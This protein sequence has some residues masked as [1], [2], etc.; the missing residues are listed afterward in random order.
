MAQTIT[1]TAAGR[2]NRRFL[3]LALILAGLSAVLAYAALSRSG[4]ETSS[5]AGEIPVVV[6]RVPIPAG[7]I[8]AL[9]MVEVR[10][11]AQRGVGEGAFIATDDVVGRV[12]RYPI[13]PNEQVLSSKV[14]G[15]SIG[16]SRALSYVLP[17][18]SRGLAISVDQV[19]GAGGLV[20][21]GDHVDVI[22]IP[23]AG[24]PAFTLLS[25]VEVTAVSQTIV[26]V[27][28]VAPGLREEDPAAGGAAAEEQERVRASDSPPLP[29]AVTITMLLS[30]AQAVTMTC[31]ENYAHKNDGHV[32]LAVRAFG[33][34]APAQVDAPPCPPLDLFLQL[35]G[36]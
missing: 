23:F 19:I 24:A 5:G 34:E 22:W 10:N 35:L 28:P 32:R 11:I 27:A 9:E 16:V 8:I 15:T 6:A 3:L 29:E 26:D 14:V 1:T 4:E 17:D 7:T 25:N 33:D 12:A 18:G 21:P 2:V 36:D 20:L 30:P 31:A 13:A